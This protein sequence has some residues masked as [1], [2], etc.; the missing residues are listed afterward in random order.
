MTV[1]LD[2]DDHKH[3]TFLNIT[4][5]LKA[6]SEESQPGD[7]VFVQFSGHGGRILDDR[8]NSDDQSYDEV[9]VP[10]DYSVSGLIR[11]TLI[12]KT[13]LAPMRYGVTVTIMIDCCDNGM[14]MDLPYSWTARN[15]RQET[16]AKVSAR[17]IE[18][19]RNTICAISTRS[20][21]YPFSPQLTMNEEFSFVRFLKVVRTLY[22][23]ST[24]TQ[25]GKTV[26]SALT[27]A[28]PPKRSRAKKVNAEEG[29]TVKIASPISTSIFDVIDKACHITPSRDSPSSK[30]NGTISKRQTVPSQSLMDQV[31]SCTLVAHPDDEDWDDDDTFNTRTY[32]EQSFDT[33]GMSYETAASVTED[34]EASRLESRK[35]SRRGR[36]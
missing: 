26:G 4:E 9:I 21:E 33:V 5:A 19:T 11:D 35:Q 32:D 8:R 24:F 27:P 6:L 22:E 31:M 13:L 12:F 10:S 15:E 3:P 2:D 25:L 23:T 20:N 1:L 14:V 16:L 36:V 29:I 18:S 17:R 7:A 30:Q 34:D 28:P